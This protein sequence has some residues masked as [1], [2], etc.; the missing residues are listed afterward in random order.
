MRREKPF[1]E[2]L[3][4]LFGGLTDCIFMKFMELK[5]IVILRMNWG[6]I[7]LAFKVFFSHFVFQG[8]RP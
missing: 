7:L 2:I 6:I 8:W 1:D 5:Y 3:L 4:K